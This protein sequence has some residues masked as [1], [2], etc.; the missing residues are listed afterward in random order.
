MGSCSTGLQRDQSD[1]GMACKENNRLCRALIRLTDELH[2]NMS[3]FPL[4]FDSAGAT[5]IRELDDRTADGG[6]VAVCAQ[7][8]DHTLANKRESARQGI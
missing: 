6:C 5:K 3:C 1:H 7:P 2:L 4:V 8:K